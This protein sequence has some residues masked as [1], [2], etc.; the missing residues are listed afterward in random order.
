MSRLQQLKTSRMKE[1][2]L[3]KKVELE[4]MC[5]RTHMVMEVLIST[6]CSIEAMESGKYLSTD[7]C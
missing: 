2:V 4:D 7:H 5:R 3:K 6:D 1:I